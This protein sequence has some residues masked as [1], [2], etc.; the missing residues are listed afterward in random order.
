MTEKQA[1][2]AFI[3]DRAEGQLPNDSAAR[4]FVDELVAGLAEGR[5]I[6][7]AAAGEYAD[8]E[9]RVDRIVASRADV[10]PLVRRPSLRS[11]R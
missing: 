10:R 4:A 2:I 8:L 3:L 11:V 5:H 9:E 6:D 7:C 1:T